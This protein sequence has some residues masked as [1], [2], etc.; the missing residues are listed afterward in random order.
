MKKLVLILFVSISFVAGALA[1]KFENNPKI[2]EARKKFF[3]KELLLTDAENKAF[4]P[5]FDKYQKENRALAKQYRSKKHPETDQGYNDKI[6]DSIE[7][8]EKKA[9]LKKKY[10]EQFS[11]VLPV[12]KVAKIE[13]TEQK[14]KRE[15]LKRV[16]KNRNNRN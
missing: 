4:W 10:L 15:V 1:Q 12:K 14:F 6:Q 11:K 5:I 8:D 9:A 13:R 16:R 2:K 3:N 7:F